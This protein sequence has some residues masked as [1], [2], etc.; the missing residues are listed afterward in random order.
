[1]LSTFKFTYSM[2]VE[3]EGALEV[4]EAELTDVELRH[5]GVVRRVG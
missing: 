2:F 5:V 1:M 4:L 3:C